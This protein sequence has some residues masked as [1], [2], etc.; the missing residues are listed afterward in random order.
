MTKSYD[1][2]LEDLA[3]RE[4]GGD[5]KIVNK[6]GYLG[7]YQV[8]EMALIDT[9]YYRNDGKKGN[10]SFKDSYWTGKDGVKS[11]QDFLNNPQAQENAIR[12]LHEVYWRNIQNKGLDRFVGKN[13][14]GVMLTESGLLAGAHLLG[15]GGLEAF[16]KRGVIGKDQFGTA[17]V[18]YMTRFAGYGTPFKA[19]RQ[20]TGVQKDK[21]GK[22]TAYQVDNTVW[23]SVEKAIQ[24][25]RDY[26]LD[27]VIVTNAKGAIFLRTR[28]DRILKNNLTK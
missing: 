24:M 23:V 11:K 7:K 9:G 2:F 8:G 22:V 18:E 10:N 27:G 20:L 14:N 6:I 4:S 21:N 1:R 16:V 12:N 17:I 19:R 13:V 5:Y 25:V 15:P 28:P 26:L 3:D